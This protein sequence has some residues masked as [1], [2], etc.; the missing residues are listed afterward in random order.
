MRPITEDE[1]KIVHSKLLELMCVFK[2]ICD[3]EHIWYSLAYGTVLGAV[4]H[5]GFIPWDTDADVCINI[6]DKDKIRN[7]FEKYAPQGIKLINYNKEKKYLSSHDILCFDTKQIVDGIH[8]DIYPLVGA[9]S[10]Y[11]E[12]AKFTKYTCIMDKI[13]RSKYSKLKECKKKNRFFVS[14]VKI[15][16]FFVP[17]RILRGN[18]H[19]RESK[20]PID[21]SE[22]VTTL[23]NYGNPSSCIKKEIMLN[24]SE[25][26]FESY[27]F[28]I[29]SDYDKYLTGIYGD[30]MTPKKY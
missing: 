18:I 4:R 3:K 20:Y 13:I 7:A 17:D 8:L 6:N 26:F 16:L 2:D 10:S 22:Y 29:P 19:Y 27:K 5:K 23:A 21:T 24:T 11:E 14:C 1:K 15:L 30:Y 12:Q 28:N 9:P 25:A